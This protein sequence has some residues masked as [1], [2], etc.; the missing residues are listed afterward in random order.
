[1]PTPNPLTSRYVFSITV[2]ATT[3]DSGLVGVVAVVAIVVI[4]LTIAKV[5][6]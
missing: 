5:E 3:L 2:I 4:A 1:M 6:S